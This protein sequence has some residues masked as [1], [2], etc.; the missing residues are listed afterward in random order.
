MK[1]K[2]LILSLFLI[3]F[4]TSAQDVANKKIEG[5]IVEITTNEPLQGASVQTY[6]FG[7]GA[8]SD[9][10]GKFSLVFK[11]SYEY[12]I[13][14]FVGYQNDTVFLN[15]QVQFP[16]TV[17]LKENLSLQEVTIESRLKGTEIDYLK[18][19]KTEKISSKELMKAA[20]CNL[21][22]SFETTPS[23]DV[24]FTDAVTGYKTI[25]ML[26]LASPH[27]SFTRENIPDVRGLASITGLTFTPGTWVNSMQLSKGAGSVVNGYEGTAGQINVEWHKPFLEDEPKWR[28]NGYQSLHGRSEGNLVY[29]HQ[30]NERLSSNLLLH[31]S[32]NWRKNDENKDGFLDNPLGKSLVAANRW[33]YF[34]EKG[35][36]IQAGIKAVQSD[37]IGGQSSFKDNR[38]QAGIWGYKQNLK[39]IEGWT[40]IGKVYADQ[41]WKSMG[42]QLAASYH[43]QESKFGN[44]AYDAKQNTFYANYIYQTIIG[45]TDHI[46]KSGASF[47]FDD[48]KEHFIGTDYNRKEYTPGA[49]LEYSYS[50]GKTFNIVAGLRADYHSIFGAFITPRLHA[51]YAPVENSVFRI[52]IGR[53]QRSANLFAEHTAYLASNRQFHLEGNDPDGIYGFKPE[54]AWNSGLSFTQDFRLNYRDGSVSFDYYYTHFTDQIVVDIE[55]PNKVSFYNLEGKSFA[56]SFQAQMDYEPIRKFDVKLAYRFYNVQT[57]YKSGLQENPLVAKHRAFS[58]FG[59][60]TNNNWRFDYTL[61]WHGPK[62]VPAHFLNE[63]TAIANDYSPSFIQMNA[64][65]SKGWKGDL[66][67]IYLGAENLTNYMQPY[68]ILDA[69]NP[70]GNAFDGSLVWGPGMGRN[71]YLGF[72]YNIK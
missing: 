61:Q 19:A 2:L 6:P 42:L 21:S 44:K 20:C 32:S 11:D 55:N 27:T 65:I 38:E 31:T 35:F 48:F 8:I 16:I 34:N 66:F 4:Q 54:V 10:E 56:H 40:K 67:Q 1:S 33:F 41:P 7:E 43:D 30:F 3:A 14:S 29:N 23:V 70:F 13:F 28:L 47:V 45:T 68:I 9:F 15:P 53:A 46:V 59:Y 17:S 71:I 22:E 58:N 36:E 25:Q 72:R 60:E 63:Q 64:Q 39:R 24:G 57:A 49:F 37:H 62:R 18:T 5:K 50:R 51:R 12:L 69:E 26:G 52:S